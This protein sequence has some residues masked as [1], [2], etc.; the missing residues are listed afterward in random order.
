MLVLLLLLR[1]LIQKT[2][3]AARGRR[4]KTSEGE[5]QNVYVHM[6]TYQRTD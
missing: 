3:H 1:H 2:A 6:Y 5:V 4:A